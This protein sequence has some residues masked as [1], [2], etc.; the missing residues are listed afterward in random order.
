MGAG[1]STSDD[2]FLMI[3]FVFVVLL[4]SSPLSK[5]G[6]YSLE[7]LGEWSRLALGAMMGDNLVECE[8]GGVN[9]LRSDFLAAW[10]TAG[11]DSLVLISTLSA[12]G[13]S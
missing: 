4:S 11:L 6:R 2:L 3:D 12:S 1:L 7:E 10:I 9:R 13:F 5:L 8:G